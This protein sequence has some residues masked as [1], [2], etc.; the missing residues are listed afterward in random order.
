MIQ[1]LLLQ[2][3]FNLTHVLYKLITHIVKELIM[4]EIIT[5]T[6]DL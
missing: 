5:V 1:I 6:N 4:I 3:D 2:T